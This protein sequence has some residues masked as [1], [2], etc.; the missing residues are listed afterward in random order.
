M[1]VILALE[2]ADTSRLNCQPG[3]HR[4]TMSQKGEVRKEEEIISN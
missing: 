3:L 2:E 4:K 1:P